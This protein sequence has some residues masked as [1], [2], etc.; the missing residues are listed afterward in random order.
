MHAHAALD[1]GAR[2]NV[3]AMRHAAMMLSLSRT[4]PEHPHMCGPVYRDHDILDFNMRH[5]ILYTR[6]MDCAQDA[7][8][9][10]SLHKI[11]GETYKIKLY[12]QA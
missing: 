12:L 5:C 6:V 2:A 4:V 8:Q 10:I 3:Q 1:G 11:V 7:S 9:A